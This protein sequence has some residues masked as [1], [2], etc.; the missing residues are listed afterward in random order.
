[1]IDLHIHSYYSDGSMSVGEIVKLAKEKNLEA[2][3]LTDHDCIDG[4]TEALR[5]GKEYGIEVIPGIELSAKSDTETHILGYFIDIHNEG[6]NSKLEEIKQNRMNRALE[7]GEKLQKL[8]FDVSFDEAMALAKGGLVG[9]AHFAKVMENK[10]YVSSVKEAF[11]L[12]LSA[13]R[14]A[15]CENQRLTSGEAIDIIRK[16]GGRAYLAHLNQTKKSGNE[17]YEFVAKLKSEGLSGVDG[18]YSEYTVEQTEEYQALAKKLGLRISGGSD[19]HGSMKPHI[20]MGTGFGNL[21]IP[22]SVLEN[23]KK[24]K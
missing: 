23:M 18:Y 12:Y 5:L 2:I 20:S 9:R 1:M 8:G 19:F 7:T 13:G 11:A 17:L 3:S 24:D 14:P 10:G 6:L 15:Y 16:A 21:N 4:V 22:Y